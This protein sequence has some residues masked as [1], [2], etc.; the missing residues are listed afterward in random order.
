MDVGS[1]KPLFREDELVVV[2]EAQSVF[3][4]P[5]HQDQFAL[6]FEQVKDVYATK[7]R[8]LGNGFRTTDAC[9]IIAI[10]LDVPSWKQVRC[11]CA[12]RRT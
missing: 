12:E 9:P 1:A 5:M 4:L 3:G 2:G 11:P 8:R 6:T 10:H 7:T